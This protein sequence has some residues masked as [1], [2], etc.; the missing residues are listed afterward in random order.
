MWLSTLE[1]HPLRPAHAHAVGLHFMALTA[2]DR[3]ARFGSSMS[4]EALLQWV[5]RLDWCSQHWWGIWGCDDVGLIATLQ[6][7]QTRTAG[8]HELALSV[9]PQTRREGLGTRILCTALAQSPE[10]HRLVCHHGDPAV[11]KMLVRM[12]WIGHPTTGPGEWRI[13]KTPHPPRTR[14]PD[15]W[16]ASANQESS[17][18]GIRRI[19]S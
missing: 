6:L 15:E 7:S 12:G 2:D 8:V 14:W 16:V 1:A 9:H 3:Y 10:V 13:Q 5:N 18:G 19:T 11:L 4:D 17:L